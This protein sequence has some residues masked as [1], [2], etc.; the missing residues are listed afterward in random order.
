MAKLKDNPEVQALVAAAAE[1]ARKAATKAALDA[2]KKVAASDNKDTA[3]TE[4]RFRKLCVGAIK[5]E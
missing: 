4:N 2:V 3:R 1:K 5:G